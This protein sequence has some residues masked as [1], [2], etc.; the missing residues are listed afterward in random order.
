MQPAVDEAGG[1]PPAIHRGDALDAPLVDGHVLTG[2]LLPRLASAIRHVLPEVHA[3]WSPDG[4]AAAWRRLAEA[5]LHAALLG[6]S[7]RALLGDGKYGRGGAAVVTPAM[8]SLGIA[9]RPVA[10]AANGGVRRDGSARPVLPGRYSK[11]AALILATTVVPRLYAELGRRRGRELEER[12][13]EA[14]M[15]ELRREYAAEMA[16]YNSSRSNDGGAGSGGDGRTRLGR[17]EAPPPTTSSSSPRLLVRKRAAER[18]AALVAFLSDLILGL[19]DMV[20]PPLRLANH[21]AY[22]WG[23]TGAPG[24]GATAAGWEYAPAVGDDGS[25][26]PPFGRGFVREACR[27]AP[28]RRHVNYQ[29][30]IR[31][32]MVEEGLRTARAVLPDSSAGGGDAQ[33]RDG[34]AEEE[35]GGDGGDGDG[36]DPSAPGLAGRLA[37]LLGVRRG[38]VA[39]DGTAASGTRCGICRAPRPVVPYVT[40]CGHVYCYV[41]LRLAATDGM[42]CD[43]AVCGR[44]VRSSRRLAATD[45]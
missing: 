37:S 21:L 28:H 24:L 26:A 40:D 27:A 12:D 19:G 41:C 6:G 4:A 17:D 7:C 14:R 30:G 29:Y 33:H 5:A 45:G 23:V 43:C 16:Y 42:G 2:L 31:R 32:L 20:L 13:R 22:L 10:A 9:M 35:D 11:V 15:A 39:G 3:G 8:H 25:P 38:D 36:V 18:R 34:P 1:P 44:A